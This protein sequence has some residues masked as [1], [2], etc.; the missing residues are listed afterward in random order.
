MTA[1]EQ[2][3]REGSIVLYALGKKGLATLRG[4]M[5]SGAHVAL[6]VLDRDPGVLDDFSAALSATAMEA[7]IRTT[8]R[9]DESA[10]DLPEN[11]LA[12]AAGWRWMIRDEPTRGLIVLHDSLLPRYRGFAPLVNALI[13]G[14]SELGVTA[15]WA[16]ATYDSGPIIAQQRFAVRYPV[17]IAQVIDQ[18]SEAYFEV[19][20]TIGSAFRSGQLPNGVAQDAGLASISVWRDEDD[21]A[22][23]W[24]DDAHR[25]QRFVDAVGFPYG[26]ARTW[27]D[28]VA[29]IVDQVEVIDDVSFELVHPGKVYELRDG[30]PSI[31]CGSG[32]VRITALRLAASG[33]NALPFRRLRTRFR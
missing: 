32:A 1:S 25:V 31:I 20:K 14:E 3:H 33:A 2:R 11:S 5:S 22:I 21:Y 8:Y 28:D 7:A 12:I 29:Y 24:S 6:V 13:N 9:G 27:S 16:A 19:A 26:G 23:S 10:A 15:I 17:T 18:A 4:L 30:C